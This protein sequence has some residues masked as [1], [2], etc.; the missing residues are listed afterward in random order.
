MKR[1]AKLFDDFCKTIA[2][3]VAPVVPVLVGSGMLRVVLILLGPNAFDILKECDN[4]FIVLSFV[5]DAGYYFLPIYISIS[6]AEYFKTNKYISALMGG[7]LV[8][9]TFIDYINQGVNLSVFKLPIAPVLYA[10]QILPSIIIIFFEKNVLMFFDNH[11]SENIKGI[12]VPLLTIVVMTPI[13]Y[14][15]VGP[16]GIILGNGLKNLILFLTNIG[17]I[18][19]AIYAALMPFIIIFGLGGTNLTIILSIIANGP[20][21]IC[22]FS[23]VIFNCTVGCVAIAKYLRDKKPDSLAAGITGIMGGISEPALYGAAAKDRKAMFAT[24]SG[25]F[26]GGFL[27]GLFGVKSF[28]VASFGVFGIVATIGK[29]S[30][31][32]YAAISLL[33]ACFIGFNLYLISH[34]KKK[35]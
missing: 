28:T 20:D 21:P 19:I 26:I 2:G 18:G 16:L 5:A 11:I 31:I 27:S 13:A 1:I 9:P 15:V 34:K 3:C 24:I 8:I 23:N 10:N 35:A 6:S 14:C 33:V 25:C 4:T 22:F 17:P 7:I 12:F 32:V 29:D 30:S